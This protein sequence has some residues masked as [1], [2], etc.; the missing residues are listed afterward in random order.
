M[1]T[2]T[3]TETVAYQTCPLCEAACGLEITLRDGAA[4]RVRGDRDDPLSKGYLCPKGASL[5]SLHDDPDR[6]RW[7]LVR[8][9]GEL[10]EVSW[11][12]AFAET[13]HLLDA[14]LARHGRAALASYVGNPASH[15]LSL[16]LYGHHVVR[17]AGP[18]RFS[19]GSV[20]TLPR[21]FSSAQ[22]FGN[23]FSMPVADVDHTD[24]LVV[25]GAN[26]LVSNGSL[27]TTPDVG[28]RLRAIQARGGRIVVVDPRRTKTAELADEHLAIR[29]A[30]DVWLL[31]ALV[32]TVL[33]AGPRLRAATGLVNGLDDLAD[34]VAP[35]GP[36]L[37]ARHTGISEDVIE[38]LAHDLLASPTA[39][40]YGRIGT[41]LQEH[42]AVCSWLIDVL[43]ILTGNLD[44][45]GGSVFSMPV[46]ERRR[47]R[48]S[49]PAQ[50][51]H[52]GRFRSRVA[53]LPEMF[54]ELPSAALADDVLVEGEGRLRG[55][56]TIAGNP[57][58]SVPDSNRMQRA[59]ADL[60][61]LICVDSYLN[62][63]TRHA[64]VVFPG[65]SPLQRPHFPFIARWSLRRYARW[66]PGTLPATEVRPNEW[67][68]A[69]IL[70]GLLRGES[71][72]IDPAAQDDAMLRA[73]IE[74]EAA[75]SQSAIS[76]RD[77]D[78]ILCALG[79]VPGPERLMDLLLRL[80]LEGDGFGA[81]PGGLSLGAL[82]A[83]P[84]GVDLGPIVPQLPDILATRSGMIE[85]APALLVEQLHALA[86][87]AEELL[88]PA[89]LVLIGRRNLR[90]NNSWMHNLKPLVR[91][92]EQC[93]LQ[94]H[95]VDAA[96]LRLVDGSLVE[97][98]SASGTVRAVAEVTDVMLPGVVSLP[99]GWGHDQ[100][101]S[102]L[103]IAATV[104]GANANALGDV[105]LVDRVTGTSVA[106]G[107]PVR[108]VPVDVGPRAL[109][110]D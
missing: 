41:C 26:P 51:D 3:T 63:T 90:S 34:A 89:A 5:I 93:T 58:L 30:T 102:R 14:F 18:S 48:S 39:V 10:C 40:V 33:A 76:G 69:L 85:L 23:G 59:L 17:A 2:T 82:R 45:P 29:P 78:E 55:L 50:E 4:M 15:N 99:H 64:H 56:V 73:R 36:D 98:A 24:L 28:S 25:L 70:A 109:E 7:P 96:R 8:R 91:G 105:R 79:P 49:L 68:I 1:V 21:Q 32:R 31:A 67:E 6:L 108:I 92:R 20:D 107:I 80:G 16:L 35:F 83:A 60:E 46:T 61:L 47:N 86:G 74:R 19:S 9:D 87:E 44:R 53:G 13:A 12:E 62:E 94:V 77:V 81:R 75:D 103:A 52:H 95:P 65:E 11:D 100:R 97:V 22:L 84:H 88:D 54:G 72:P 27:M 66:T 38:R 43:N 104:P 42:G 37:A 101:G 106:S 110:R 71:L 57:A